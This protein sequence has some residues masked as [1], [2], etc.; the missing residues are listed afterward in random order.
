MNYIQGIKKHILIVVFVVFSLST[1]LSTPNQLV[2]AQSAEELEQNIKNKTTEL[3]KLEEQAEKI[4]QELSEVGSEKATLNRELSIINTERKSLENNIE[5]TQASIDLLDSR[6]KKTE[7]A[8]IEH[9]QEIQQQSKVLG[10]LVRKIDQE[11]RVSILEKM[12][13]LG[14]LS[15]IVNLRDSYIRLQDPVREYTQTLRIN[16]QE[17]SKNRVTLFSQQE[18]LESETE[19]LSD[20]KSIV[21]EQES[22][23][24][25]VLDQT[26]NIE[27]VYQ[28]NLNQTL[29]TI[30]KLDDEIRDFES[31][32][33]FLLDEGSLPS[34]G[35][36]VLAWPLDKVLITQ[37]FGKTVSSK[38]LY[39]SGS[40]SGMDFR[41]A[42][43][44]PVYAVADGTVGGVGNTDDTCPN[45]SFGKWVFI[46]HDN[47]LSTTSGHLSLIK[48][49][50]GQKVKKG[51]II[52]Y[53]GNTGRST[54]PHLHLT[55]YATKGVN[56]EDGA[57][58]TNRA[59]A[60]CAGKTYRMPLAP[61]SAYLDPLAYLP[62]TDT[63]YFKH[64]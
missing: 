58:V 47:G 61:T 9:S 27:S 49:S 30:A 43:G 53:S 11:D 39:V 6:I 21:E 62:A 18:V 55:V 56:G 51:D 54:A 52:A 26:K 1:L 29:A 38:R 35:S 28:Q 13:N 34:E 25:T 36:S 33:E 59:S 31:K 14:T 64:N 2:H 57:R 37:R 63:S 24:Q 23:K 12:F 7:S 10:A 41:A 46:E 17:L 19:K 42:V 22:K 5:Q 32:L 8:I 48:V 40:H 45:A 4:K 20:Q 3:K 50:S 16:R 60:A 44:T 15:E